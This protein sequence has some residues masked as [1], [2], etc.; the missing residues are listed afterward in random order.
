MVG[1]LEVWKM[2]AQMEEGINGWI[3]SKRVLISGEAVAVATLQPCS[4][5]LTY[6]YWVSRPEC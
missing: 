5:R 4:I 1:E 2:G 6:H 3:R